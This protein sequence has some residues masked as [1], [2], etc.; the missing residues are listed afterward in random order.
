MFKR[1]S[2][3]AIR[4]PLGDAGVILAASLLYSA[5]VNM[6]I[7]PAKLIMGG[8]TG[9]ATAVNL[10]FGVP[11]IGV[12]TMLLN[13]PLLLIVWRVYGFRFIIKTA[14]ATFAVSLGMDLCRFWPV[15]ELTPLLCAVFGGITTGVAMGLLFSRGYNT[16]GTDLIVYLLRRKWKRLSPGGIIFS[17]DCFIIAFSAFALHSTTL[18]FYSMITIYVQTKALDLVVNGFHRGSAAFIISEKEKEIAKALTE[19]LERGVTVLQGRGY[20]SGEQREVLLCAVPSGEVYK[21]KKLVKK[22]DPD[23]FL[24]I[25]DAAEISGFG[26]EESSV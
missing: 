13:I 12:M 15:E 14:V 24:I 19:D 4:R 2:K 9:L 7:E 8:M 23:A 26:F 10:L 5:G 18:V 3:E 6:F 21:L 22:Y 11:P 25:T 17:I 1:I 16:G 20:F